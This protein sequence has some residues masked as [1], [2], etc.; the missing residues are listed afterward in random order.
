MYR[1]FKPKVCSLEEKRVSVSDQQ[2]RSHI[3][4]RFTRTFFVQMSFW[5]IFQ[6]TCT[7][8]KLLKQCSYEKF[9]RKNVDEIDNRSHIH[10]RFIRTFFIRKCFFAKTQLEKS[11]SYEKGTHKT[12]MKL[13]AGI[14][15]AAFTCSDPKIAKNTVTSSVFFTLLGLHA[16]RLVKSTQGFFNI[17]RAFPSNSN[18]P[19]CRQFHQ[20][21]MR[22]FFVRTLF[23][24]LFFLVNQ[25]HV[26]LF[27]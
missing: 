6:V 18:F 15:R 20:R 3:H 7:Q 4:Q 10:Q 9:V 1:V 19:V 23:R 25:L 11:L 17:C 26:Q 14:L 24:Q 8:K 22:E 2:T 13:R 5:Q 21:Y 16:L 27:Q 12:L